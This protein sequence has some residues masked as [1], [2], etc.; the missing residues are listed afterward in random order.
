M[1]LHEKIINHQP[2]SE[3][4][5]SPFFTTIKVLSDEIIKE[6]RCKG[7]L[8]K[9]IEQYYDINV[10]LLRIEHEFYFVYI[11]QSNVMHI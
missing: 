10:I 5:I 8:R 2:L 1:F 3:S 4:S 9:K 6:I 7:T 11:M